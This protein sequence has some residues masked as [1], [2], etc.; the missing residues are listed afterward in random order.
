M[1]KVERL[2]GVALWVDSW[3][4]LLQWRRLLPFTAVLLGLLV[5]EWSAGFGWRGAL[6]SFGTSLAFWGFA[7]AWWRLWPGR[8]DSGAAAM[9]AYVVGCLLVVVAATVGLG[10]LANARASV[11]SDAAG[12][13]VAAVL[14][15]V[16][17]WGL[18]RDIELAA[19]LHAERQH[20]AALS[21]ELEM[22]RLLAVRRQLDP[23]FLFN[24]LNAI[25]EWCVQDPAVAERATLQLAAMLRD[26]LDGLQQSRWPL[27]EEVA[28]I[29]RLWRLH[30]MRDPDKLQLS[31]KGDIDCGLSIPP[32]LLLPLAENAVTHGVRAGH[33]GEVS[34]S[35]AADTLALVIS[36]ENPGP[37]RGPR[38]DR[39]G[40]EAFRLR[41]RAAYGE[42][43]SFTIQSCADD[44]RT[45][46][47][48]RIAQ[49]STPTVSPKI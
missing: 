17:G 39:H 37:Y 49:P 23:H 8:E 14:F 6:V 5:A 13:P 41:L 24:T 35:I 36:L 11:L 42:R 1:L 31:L 2:R 25:A 15:M 4:A 38:P 29:E 34:L 9:V 28:L 33:A 30:R 12:W 47:T 22:A 32:L 3:R 43:A 7:P 27:A 48:V 20:N 46:A 18:G 44:T 45:L 19:S 26:M 40:L 10:R 21:H 16:G